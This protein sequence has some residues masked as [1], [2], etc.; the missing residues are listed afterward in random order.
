MRKYISFAVAIC[1]L[2]S[3]LPASVWGAENTLT[4]V[5]SL[6]ISKNEE[7]GALVIGDEKNPTANVGYGGENLPTY[8]ETPDGVGYLT[9]ANWDNITNAPINTDRYAYVDIDFDDAATAEHETIADENILIEMW[10]RPYSNY[11]SG[12]ATK[13]LYSLNDSVVGNTFALEMN[14]V[15]MGI[16]GGR[17]NAESWLLQAAHP[18]IGIKSGTTATAE[19]IASNKAINGN[20][21]SVVKD[22]L[23]LNDGEW[24]HF[25]VARFT[26]TDG[27]LRESAFI[28]GKYAIGDTG[29]EKVIH[30]NLKSADNGDYLNYNR[31]TFGKAGRAGG[32][33]IGDI[34]VCNIY[35]G[36]TE[37]TR[38]DILKNH[39][40]DMYAASKE[41]YVFN[42]TETRTVEVELTN[43]NSAKITE[44][45]ITSASGTISVVAEVTDYIE[46]KNSQALG[47]SNAD[48]AVAVGYRDEEAICISRIPGVLDDVNKRTLFEG[49]LTIPEG[50]SL[51]DIRVFV[52]DAPDTI[53]PIMQ[54]YCLSK[55]T[56]DYKL[57]V[58]PT[59]LLNPGT[60]KMSGISAVESVSGQ[61]LKINDA[62]YLPASNKLILDVSGQGLKSF[63]GSVTIDDTIKFFGDA[64]GERTMTG[65]LVHSI[66]EELFDLNIMS[67]SLVNSVGVAVQS[68]RYGD[69]YRAVVVVKNT[70]FEDKEGT[71]SVFTKKD[72]KTLS[73]EEVS[74]AKGETKTFTYN[75]NNFYMPVGNALCADFTE[76]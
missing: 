35:T 54:A 67:V 64:T 48:F 71:L 17:V 8:G 27:K 9:L 5:F 56:V 3:L 49:E 20:Q 28:N 36:V 37:N 70:S 76:E 53:C 4:E 14:F 30:K 69:T 15:N 25:V 66:P 63:T 13:G 51:D 65:N 7:T 55:P 24:I 44:E 29:T 18:C 72:N 42:T 43:D 57:E 1:L 74:V 62:V 10:I 45:N 12:Y 41:N 75:L 40:S 39:I 32:A 2:I 31:M 19:L 47:K 61:R 34:A 23:G 21:G 60:V 52:W 6:K 58:T 38:Q 68:T 16:A 33:F 26:D 22:Q 11:Y 73:A 50:K 59:F 46:R